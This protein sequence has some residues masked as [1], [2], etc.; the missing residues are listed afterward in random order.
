MVGR[1]MAYFTKA[2]VFDPT[3]A[4]HVV[5]RALVFGQDTLAEKWV[6]SAAKQAEGD[7]QA[8]DA[9]VRKGQRE[10]RMK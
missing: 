7:K 9:Q 3:H 1:A 4:D 2:L 5:V 8:L 10:R 6:Q